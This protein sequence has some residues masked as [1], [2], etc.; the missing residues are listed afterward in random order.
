MMFPWVFVW[1]DRY[2]EYSFRDS[3]RR[4]VSDGLDWRVDLKVGRE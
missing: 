1:S 3:E 2:D 4:G